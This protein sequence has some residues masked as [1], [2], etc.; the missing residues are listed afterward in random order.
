M[1]LNFDL[2]RTKQSFRYHVDLIFPVL[3]YL[4]FNVVNEIVE[5]SD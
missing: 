1:I 4:V 3:F 2:Q 5:T